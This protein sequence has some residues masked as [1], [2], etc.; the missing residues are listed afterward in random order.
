MVGGIKMFCF[1][2]GTENN[3]NFIFCYHCGEKLQ[4]P[5][6]DS[7]IQLNS[8]E[9]NIIVPNYLLLAILSTVFCCMPLGIVAIVFA[10]KVDSRL[11]KG[12]YIK[13]KEASK[14]AK[15]FIW[16]S[17]GVG[18]LIFLVIISVVVITFLTS[19]FVNF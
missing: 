17:F 10:C 2:C 7:K 18:I 12:S 6:V 14:I 5:I 8:S 1:K 4:P 15:V 13:A 3:D 11:E 9:A 19:S 16:I